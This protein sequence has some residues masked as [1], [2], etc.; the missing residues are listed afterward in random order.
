MTP[1]PDILSSSMPYFGTNKIFVSNDN[2]LSVTQIGET[3]L[4]APSRSFNLKDVLIVPSIKR[5]LLFVHKFCDD[6]S[7]SFEFDSIGFCVKDKK[8]GRSS[9]NAVHWDDTLPSRPSN[10]ASVRNKKTT[11]FASKFNKSNLW[12]IG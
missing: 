11:L 8:P 1:D 6:N 9:S 5:N 2:L 7:S 12:H 10:V 4:N 3:E